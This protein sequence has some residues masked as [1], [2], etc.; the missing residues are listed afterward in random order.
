MPI[1]PNEKNII[2]LSETS[3]NESKLE[4]HRIHKVELKGNGDINIIGSWGYNGSDKGEL[5]NPSG[6]AFSGSKVYVSEI[7]NSRLQ[8]FE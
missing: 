8:I 4:K 2:Y 7:D 1:N 6:I 5:D 3:T